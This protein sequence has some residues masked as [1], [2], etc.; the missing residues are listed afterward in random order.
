MESV[1]MEAC[2]QKGPIC[3]EEGG[4]SLGWR[5]SVASV[6]RFKSLNCTSSNELY[7]SC[8]YCMSQC[9]SVLVQAL[10]NSNLMMYYCMDSS[11]FKHELNPFPFLFRNIM[12]M[13]IKCLSTY[14][15]NP[16]S[17]RSCKKV[18][19]QK[20]QCVAYAATVE[21]PVSDHPW[22]QAYVIAYGRWSLTESFTNSNLT[23][24]GTSQ[25]FG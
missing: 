12:W 13:W 21:P 4:S 16:N 11:M 9:W 3:K 15:Q 5:L 2:Y 25:H 22:C 20:V 18:E 24:G 19:K 8:M 1:Y 14:L 23:D 7:V 6:T 17:T 10:E